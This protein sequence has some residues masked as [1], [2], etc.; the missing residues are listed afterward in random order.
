[1]RCKDLVGRSEPLKLFKPS[2]TSCGY[3]RSQLKI[4]DT[5]F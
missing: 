3:Y 5:P 2:S 4:L 1:M